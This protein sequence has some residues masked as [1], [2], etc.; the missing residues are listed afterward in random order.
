MNDAIIFQVAKNLQKPFIP[1]AFQ[2]RFAGYKG[3]LVCDPTLT[4]KTAKFRPSM[5]KFKSNHQRLEVTNTSRPQPV[6]LNHQV[7]MLLSN[8]GVSDEIFLSMQKEM[9]HKLGGKTLDMHTIHN[10]F[11]DCEMFLKKFS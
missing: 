1:S 8:L 3:V 7:I 5:R 4:G 9:L 2:V 6:Y 11:V 10:H